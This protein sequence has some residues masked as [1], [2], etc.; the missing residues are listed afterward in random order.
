MP[1]DANTF[2]PCG[3]M[4]SGRQDNFL[5]LALQRLVAEDF[6]AE[7]LMKL[8]SDRSETNQGNLKYL[9]N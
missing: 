9:C 5:K 8:V 1:H 4:T 2:S 7:V 6:R 3:E